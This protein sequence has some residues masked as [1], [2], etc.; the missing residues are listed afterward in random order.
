MRVRPSPNADERPDDCV[1]DCLILHYTGMQSAEAA[2]QRLCDPAAKV[3]AHYLIDADGSVLRLVEDDRRAWHAG[4]SFWQG[5]EQLNDVSIGI[6][7]VNP[8][9]EWGYR[10]FTEAQYQALECL[11]PMIMNR[12]SIPRSRVLAHSDVAPDRKE[13]PGELFDWQRLARAGVGVWPEEGLGEP[14]SLAAI[15]MQLATIG[16]RIPT[17]GDRDVETCK[18]LMAFQRHFRPERV[19]G[20]LDQQTLARLDGLL[21]TLKS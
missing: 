8:G 20:D 10:P 3:S 18:V 4:V 9:H 15:Q 5:R 19:G 12:W 2:I 6:E 7:V 14:R 11:G 16:Y 17:H 21:S 13:D 1:V